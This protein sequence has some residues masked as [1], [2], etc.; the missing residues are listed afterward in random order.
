LNVIEVL[1]ANRRLQPLE[2]LHYNLITTRIAVGLP[3]AGDHINMLDINLFRT[4]VQQSVGQQH[5]LQL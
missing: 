1:L 4:G 3:A 5:S 2:V